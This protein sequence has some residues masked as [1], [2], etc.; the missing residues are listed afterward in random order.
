MNDKASRQVRHVEAR[1]R[2][3]LSL[4]EARHAA[5]DSGQYLLWLN[6]KQA[7]N[8]REPGW[9]KREPARNGSVL[10]VHPQREIRAARKRGIL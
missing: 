4:A 7:Q 5:K 6:E 10:F 9:I 1:E 8:F 3:V 2:Q